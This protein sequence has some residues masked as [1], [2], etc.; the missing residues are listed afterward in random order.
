MNRITRLALVSLAALAGL[1]GA[2]TSAFAMTPPDDPGH[3]QPGDWG[4]FYG[5]GGIPASIQPAQTQ[6]EAGTGVS[7]WIA[8]ALAAAIVI[9][10]VAAGYWIIRSARTRADSSPAR[11]RAAAFG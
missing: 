11:P 1:V 6:V 7:V 4:G 9:A 2:P 8:F 5:Q 3:P 10:V